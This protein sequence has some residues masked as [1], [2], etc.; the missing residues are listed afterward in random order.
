MD[1]EPGSTTP[2]TPFGANDVER[3]LRTA[4]RSGQNGDLATAGKL[5]DHVLA[6]EPRNREALLGRAALALD[7]ASQQT[8]PADRAAAVEKAVTL[9]QTLRRVF[10]LPKPN[11][12]QLFGQAIFA[13][14]R[15]QVEQGR[16]DQ[17][18]ALLKEAADAGID[19]Y[20]PVEIEESMAPLR[21]SPQF[22][23]ALKAKREG[24]VAEARKRINDMLDKPLDFP[25]NFTLAD[26]EGKQV[27][28]AD[29]KGKIVL[30]DFWGTWCGPCR[31][32]I[33]R[34]IE[35]YRT[36]RH[37]GLEVVGLCYEK[38]HSSEAEARTVLKRFVKETGISYPCLIGD[39]ATLRQVPNF[40][41]FPTSLVLDRSGKA[42]LLVTENQKN[43]LD[44]ITDVVEVLLA[45]PA[46]QA[47]DAVK[48]P[49]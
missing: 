33:P 36:R 31:E 38:G 12:L 35:L 23:A 41:G 8:S 2:E 1:V 49:R 29:F 40:G 5:L 26:L 24:T 6:I 18:L 22:R 10:E 14:A 3:Q 13:Q 9:M 43:T 44:M 11:E 30:V 39:E 16:N 28:L 46:P 32:A 19:L 47:G 25:F 15:I 45:D 37:R 4:I 34:L 20:S 21:S 42:R 27:S 48:K 7:Q 17:A